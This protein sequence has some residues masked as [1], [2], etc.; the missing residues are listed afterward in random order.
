MEQAIEAAVGLRAPLGRVRPVLV[1]DP[2]VVVSGAPTKE[3]RRARRFVTTLAVDLGAGSRAEQEVSVHVGLPVSTSDEVVL[4][5]EWTPTGHRHVL[6]T[7]VGELVA[8]SE[9]PGTQLELRGRYRVPLGVIGRVGDAVAG[10]R[11]A[12]K[13]LVAY[14]ESIGA[15]L[16]DEVAH[17]SAQPA[18]VRG[19]A[20]VEGAMGSE[21][22]IG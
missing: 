15:R 4:P 20:S 10:H 13:V 6:P 5:V 22:F 9:R 16:Q 3:E 17:R 11:L 12:K 7:F 2:G 14:V 19:K 18:P 21:Y 8:R 1:E